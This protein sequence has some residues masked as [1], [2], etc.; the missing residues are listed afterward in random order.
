MSEPLTHEQFVKE[1][2]KVI[3]HCEGHAILILLNGPDGVRVVANFAN[4]IVALGMYDAGKL[5][6]ERQF[7][8]RFAAAQ[9]N[10]EAKMAEQEIMDII[11][12]IKPK[13][14]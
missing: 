7:G 11:Q 12:D 1:A 13:V 5:M 10:G 8:D 2:T 14:N 6:A 4:V 3:E 9:V